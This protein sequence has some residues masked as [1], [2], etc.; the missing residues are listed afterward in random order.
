MK[1]YYPYFLVFLLF[2]CCLEIPSNASTKF[3]TNIWFNSVINYLAWEEYWFDSYYGEKCLQNMD[4]G[5]L[6]IRY[7]VIPSSSVI[8][9]G[10]SIPGYCEKINQNSK[11]IN[12]ESVLVE[13]GNFVMA[14]T[15]GYPKSYDTDGNGKLR[16]DTEKTI[17]LSNIEKDTENGSACIASKIENDLWIENYNK[18]PEIKQYTELV[19]S[20]LILEIKQKKLLQNRT[21][22][23]TVINDVVIQS[24]N[25]Y[26]SKK[27]H[28]HLAEVEHADN[29]DKSHE[30]SGD[31]LYIGPYHSDDP[32][33]VVFLPHSNELL[34]IELPS[35]HLLKNNNICLLITPLEHF[36][37]C[38]SSTEI[39]LNIH[40]SIIAK[41]EKFGKKV[42][43]KRK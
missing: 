17:V 35:E 38:N 30:A 37:G 9:Q 3:Q 13:L 10:I 19:S 29:I 24:I 2:Q 6:E 27:F 22:S 1:K 25:N 40:S 41:L 33:V 34:K 32:Y 4:V 21:T 15:L 11:R 16:Q 42:H 43:I 14:Y 31:L 7:V 12:F 23:N 39:D 18:H 36:I 8:S 5:D 28:E 26:L 20:K